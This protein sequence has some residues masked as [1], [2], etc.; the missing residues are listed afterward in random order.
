MFTIN[1]YKKWL[2]LD[3]EKLRMFLISRI[4]TKRTETA[5]KTYKLLEKK[6]NYK[7]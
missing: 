6:W 5:Y 2:P 1:H 4:N 3:F 7:K